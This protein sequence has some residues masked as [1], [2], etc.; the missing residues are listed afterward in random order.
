MNRFEGRTV[1]VRGA[2]GAVASV[3]GGQIACLPSI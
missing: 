2:T 1:L 3:D